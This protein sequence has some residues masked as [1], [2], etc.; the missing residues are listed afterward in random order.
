MKKIMVFS[1][2]LMMLFSGISDA[3]GS[4][5]QQATAVASGKVEVYYFH[6]TRRC[7]TCN[8][9]EIVSKKAVEAMYPKLIQSGKITFKAINLDDASSKAAAQKCGAEGQ[10]LLV[11]GGGKRIDLTSQGFMYAINNPEK[12]KAEL[13]KAIDPLI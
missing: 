4:K 10:S 8:A 13:K 6:F 5:K 11:I 9:V 1:F 3:Q 7:M 2:A 12:L